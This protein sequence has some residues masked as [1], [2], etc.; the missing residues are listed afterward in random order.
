MAIDF[1]HYRDTDLAIHTWTQNFS[2]KEFL[3]ATRAYLLSPARYEILDIRRLNLDSIGSMD[4]FNLAEHLHTAYR[5][6][7][8]VPGKTAVVYHDEMPPPYSSSQRLFHNFSIWA[9]EHRLP[10][11]F[12]LFSSMAEAVSWLGDR[13]IQ[14]AHGDELLCDMAAD[15]TAQPLSA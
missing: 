7:R 6:E 9:K 1:V 11:D 8:H 4:L 15:A 14:N 2:L 3:Q 5:A 13:R 10:R 12:A